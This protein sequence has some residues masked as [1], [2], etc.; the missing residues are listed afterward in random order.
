MNSLW[1]NKSKDLNQSIGEHGQ[2]DDN[3]GW[4]VEEKGGEEEVNYLEDYH[5]EPRGCVTN[6]DPVNHWLFARFIDVFKSG[7]VKLSITW[8]V[9]R[10]NFS[11]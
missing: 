5:I 3:E 2:V 11:I 4:D 7:F 6:P 8:N 10:E 1:E 9:V